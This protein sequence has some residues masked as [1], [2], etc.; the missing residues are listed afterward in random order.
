MLKKATT[1]FLIITLVASLFSVTAFGAELSVSN[2]V[3][4]E[5]STG[6]LEDNFDDKEPT[7]TPTNR[8]TSTSGLLNAKGY[9]NW[10]NTT[11]SIV[12]KNG[13]NVLEVSRPFN[14]GAASEPLYALKAY[15]TTDYVTELTYNLRFTDG[16]NIPG[17]PTGKVAGNMGL[18][19]TVGALEMQ[20]N[21]DGNLFVRARN[22]WTG[23]HV[24]EADKEYTVKAILDGDNYNFQTYLLD[25]TDGTILACAD[26]MKQWIGDYTGQNV[27]REF[28]CISTLKNADVDANIKFEIDNAKMV[29]YNRAQAGPAI[30][31]SSVADG[32]T[33]V[34][35]AILNSIEVEFDQNVT[36]ALAT[37]KAEGKPDITCTA[38]PVANKLNTYTLSWTGELA[39]NTT[40]TVDMSATTNGKQAAGETA[41]ITFTTKEPTAAPKLLKSTIADG[42]TGVAT[43]IKSVEVAFDIAV[44]VK[45]SLTD[46]DGAVIDTAFTPV[47]G[48]ANAYTISW[49]DNLALGTTYTLDMSDTTNADGVPAGDDAIITFTTEKGIEKLTEDFESGSVYGSEFKGSLLRLQ[50]STR[51]GRANFATGYSGNALELKMPLGARKNAFDPLVT[52]EAYAPEVISANGGE[53]E[54]EKFV[55]T[56]R[57]NLKE[58]ADVGSDTVA[59]T[60]DVSGTPEAKTAGSRILMAIHENTLLGYDK[61][62]MACIN[63]QNGKPYIQDLDDANDGAE[64]AEDHWYNIVWLVDGQDQTFRFIDAETGELVWERSI[65]AAYTA[66]TPLY[67]IP[68]QGRRISGNAGSQYF[69]YNEGQTALI[70]DFNIWRINPYANAQKLAVI[71]SDN[72][73]ELDIDSAED[74]KITITYNQPVL[75]TSSDLELYNVIDGVK[76]ELAYSTAN[77]KFADFCTQEVT[78][79]NLVY[80]GEYVL[81]YS[82]IKAVSGAEI[83]EADK[84]T[85]LVEFTTAASSDDVSIVGFG[86]GELTADSNVN[87]NFCGKITDDMNVYVAF[88]KNISSGKQLI[89]V[90]TVDDVSVT[91]GETTPVEIQLSEDYSDADCIKVF[92]WKNNGSLEPFMT[93]FEITVPKE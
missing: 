4:S 52:K 17:F 31:S 40:Y 11:C 16:V 33:A 87:F 1:V 39:A 34:N 41:K 73:T 86:A 14:E 24:I 60:G 64:F 92:A 32:A 5:N 55:V 78:F 85:S 37:L 83:A 29:R 54:Y 7:S 28:L 19:S 88:Y 90:A 65:T 15:P 62:L 82:A 18:N 57:F 63:T 46:E 91:E 2:R 27:E 81:D 50:Y 20:Y 72:D 79:S 74:N 67:I 36:T 30:A 61:S 53:I 42:A 69:V 8:Y 10:Y 58:M 38:T 51:D 9:D 66:G 13:N 89:G 23:G 71:A 21:A 68:Y 70:D 25:A 26:R 56:Y 44:T 47:A 22:V 80:S 59:D 76:N 45:A 3:I 84:P 75:G 77:I 93:A 6:I 49:E 43:T 35:P 12:S 48:K